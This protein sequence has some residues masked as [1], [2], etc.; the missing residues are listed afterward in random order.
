[1]VEAITG[2][3]DG[4]EDKQSAEAERLD[5]DRP[6]LPESSATVG[7][8]RV[9]LEGGYTFN[10]RKLSSFSSHAAPEAVFRAGM[11]ADWFEFRI[12]QNF[13]KQERTL[14][15][16][17]SKAAGPQDMY[18]GLKVGVTEQ[19][20]YV[21]EIALIPQMMVPTGDRSVTG[22]RALL[23]LNVDGGWEIIK[24]RY[25]IEFVIA[26]NR[27]AD[28]P[29]HSHFELATGITHAF[30]V[31]PR[32]EVFGEWDRFNGSIDPEAGSRHYAVGGLVF[33][34]TKNF[35]VDF[36]AG[37]GLNREAN[38]FLIGTGFAFRH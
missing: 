21:P 11:F 17:T 36:R 9:M 13:L 37:A 24:D 15:G 12:G 3:K 31:H 23:G 25:N 2:N 8:G 33:F 14:S 22:G 20:R 10:E 34:V 16:V 1:M 28:D 30:Q 18:L 5:P 4:A 38:R 29:R 27:L 35:A 26:N 32:L 7:K 6:H 19:K